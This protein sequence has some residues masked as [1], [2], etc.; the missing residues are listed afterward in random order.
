MLFGRFRLSDATPA[1]EFGGTATWP[2]SGSPGVLSDSELPP[3]GRVRSPNKDAADQLGRGGCRPVGDID[4]HQLIYVDV[5]HAF[6][7][8]ATTATQPWR[9][10]A[11]REC[12]LSM[13]GRLWEEV[14]Y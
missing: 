12:C 1:L 10:Q 9:N 14:S 8:Q 7:T 2:G 6:E 11:A 13:D 3:P 4:E 5:T